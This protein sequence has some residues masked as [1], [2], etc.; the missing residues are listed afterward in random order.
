VHCVKARYLFEDG[1]LDEANEALDLALRLDPDAWEVNREGARL[2]YRQGRTEDAARH[3]EKAVGIFET[4][5]HAWGML[6]SCYQ[7]LGDREG[8][9][10]AA[11]NMISQ[12]ERVLAEDPSNAAALGIGAGGLAILGQV[13][14]A[15]EW[16]ERA[17][18]IDPDNLNMRYNFACVTALYMKDAGAAIDLLQPVFTG[19][20]KS[21]LNNAMID[22]DLVSIRDD[23]R[24]K[25]MLANAQKRLGI[26]PVDATPPATSEP[27]RS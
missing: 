2:L 23:P 10:R 20:T 6:S 11:K 16:I 25:E 18:L 21:L 7:A 1:Q 15:K 8:V 17:L 5:F 19:L 9:L 27:L 14:R 22:P 12:S 3:F 24:F 26:E 4:D 13:D